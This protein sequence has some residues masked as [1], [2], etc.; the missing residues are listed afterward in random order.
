MYINEG[1]NDQDAG[2]MHLLQALWDKSSACLEE[3]WHTRT[4][5]I[6]RAQ[7]PGLYQAL[8]GNI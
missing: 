5:N 4:G 2:C 3:N 1:T 6:A 8:Y 7:K